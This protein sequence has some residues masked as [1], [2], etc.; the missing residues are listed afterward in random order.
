MKNNDFMGEK[1]RNARLRKNISMDD[2]YRDLRMHPKMVESFEKG[3]IDT[4]IGDIYVKAFLKKYARFLSVDLDE[5]IKETSAE[6][7]LK[8]P[9]Q[10]VTLELRLDRKKKAREARKKKRAA[11]RPRINT[12]DIKRL[13]LPLTGGFAV[14]LA[15]SVIV[16]A[17][18]N[19]M[20]TL[21]ETKLSF[22][23]PKKGEIKIMQAKS[24]PVVVS[25][26][27]VPEI[28]PMELAIETKDKVWLRVESDGKTVFEH[29]LEK[30]GSGKWPANE[31][32]GLRIGRPESI[33]LS[34][35]GK[36]LEL[37]EGSG[38]RNI[39]IDREGLKID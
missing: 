21:K 20:G 2:I 22:S 30:N 15:S 12:E 3:E 17:S 1:L 28:K 26:P 32:F 8:Q 11:I 31:K 14:L 13:G 34:V 10:E 6:E 23:E 39:T 29:T 5:I 35:D 7:L 25:L 36:P 16:Y 18:F 24:A 4:S 37:P 38:I 33:T 19:F 27:A 9:P